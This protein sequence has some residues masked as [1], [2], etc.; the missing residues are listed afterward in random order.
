[1][2]S[3]A[4][5]RPTIA[6]IRAACQP[7]DL[8]DRRSGEHWAGRLY[9]RHIS[10]YVTALLART[11]VTPNQ[12]TAVMVVCGVAAGGVLAIGGLGGAIAAA[13]LIQLYLLL[14]C[15]DGELARWTGRTSIVGVYADRVGHYLTDAALLSGLGVR[16]A[17]RHP[18]GWLLLGVV[19]AL[20]AVLGKAETD[21]VDVARA[22][23]GL[24]PV[25]DEATEPR[26]SRLGFARR[27]AS[28][29]RVHRIVQAIE[30]SLLVVVAAAYDAAVDE[31]TATRVLVAA[32]AAVAGALVVLHLVSILA[33]SRLR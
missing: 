1:V 15:C 18:S 27:A 24:P 33:S 16:A 14:D 31:L 20:C 13:V 19:A 9:M 28:V 32:C 5:A 11:P 4:A 23:S 3:T 30:L 22:R 21:L 7:T 29:F 8:L 12:V 17:S 6:E 25:T 10:V 2:P 26:S